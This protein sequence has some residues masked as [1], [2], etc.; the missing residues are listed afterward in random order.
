MNG[1]MCSRDAQVYDFE[2]GNGFE[3]PRLGVRHGKQTY[4][5]YHHVSRS[6]RNQKEFDIL[7]DRS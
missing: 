2:G 4:S 1:D 5:K 7:L 6:R 3:V